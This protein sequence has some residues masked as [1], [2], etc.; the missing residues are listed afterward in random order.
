MAEMGQLRNEL[1]TKILG[2]SDVLMRLRDGNNLFQ[3]E[4]FNLYRNTEKWPKL[5]EVIHLFFLKYK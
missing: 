5:R 4:G 1:V 2:Q 3:I